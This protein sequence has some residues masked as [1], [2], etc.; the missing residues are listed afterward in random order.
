MRKARGF[1]RVALASAAPKPRRS[2]RPPELTDEVF[3][4]HYRDH[5][6]TPTWGSD[7][8]RGIMLHASHDQVARARFRNGIAPFKGRA[9]RYA[10]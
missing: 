6:E 1:S 5:P 3:L 9:T 8:D 2:G 10:E 7:G 4:K